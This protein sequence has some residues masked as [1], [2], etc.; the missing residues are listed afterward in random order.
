VPPSCRWLFVCTL[1]LELQ[2]AVLTF[3]T[4]REPVEALTAG[5]LPRAMR[6][7]RTV[8][9]DDHINTHVGSRSAMD[10]LQATYKNDP[11][12][13]F[14]GVDNS[15]GKGNAVEK[16]IDLLPQVEENGLRERL[17]N[18]LEAEHRAGRI[19]DAVRSGTERTRRDASPDAGTGSSR[20]RGGIQPESFGAVEGNPGSDV[21]GNSRQSEPQRDGRP[22]AP[23]DFPR[24][25]TPDELKPYDVARVPIDQLHLD[26]KRF[27]Y[28]MNTDASGVTNLLKG[29]TWNEDLAGVISV[30]RDPE[31]GKTYVVNGHHRFD[32]AEKTGQPD[33]AVRMIAADDAE[34][35]RAKGAIQNI[36]EGRGTA[37]DAAKFF[38]DGDA[39]PAALDL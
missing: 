22:L 23:R 16:S 15:L 2:V 29:R 12:V 1:L 35:A 9:L 31:D 26:P 24:V 21:S 32:L 36:A 6:M 4:Y 20:G 10:V 33:V 38:R 14:T 30:W 13:T 18:A 11:R 25:T 17:Q 8:P 28:K 3:Y 27:Q 37:M 5:A 34:Q 7:G 19:S 39:T